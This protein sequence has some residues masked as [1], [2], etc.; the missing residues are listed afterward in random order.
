MDTFVLTAKESSMAKKRP[1]YPPEFRHRVLELV[2][3]RAAPCC[4]MSRE[5]D[6][7]RQSIMNWLKQDDLD[8]G[9]R[10]D[11]LTTDE[12]K[13]LRSC[14]AKISG[15]NSKRK[16]CQKP[17]PGSLGRPTR[18]RANLRIHEGVPGQ[19]HRHHAVPRSRRLPERLLCMVQTS[20]VGAP[21]SRHHARRSRLKRSFAD[22]GRRTEDRDSCRSQWMR[23][24]EFA[25]NA[26]RG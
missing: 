3:D 10:D 11:G 7:S 25:A 19:I 8:S 20:A 13:E 6:V 17:R 26:L 5:F 14:A 9:R 15:S 22:R 16:Y 12:R 1:T 4:R 18:F 23:A 21:A 2:R 24:S